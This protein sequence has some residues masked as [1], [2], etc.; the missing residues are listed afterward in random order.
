MLAIPGGQRVRHATGKFKACCRQ[1]RW[2]TTGRTRYR[3]AWSCA[4]N[5]RRLTGHFMA[6]CLRCLLYTSDAADDM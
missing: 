6:A 5:G 4:V 1:V 2:V 3:R